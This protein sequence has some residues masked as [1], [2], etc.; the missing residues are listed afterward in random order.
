MPP[1]GMN[2]SPEHEFFEKL[3]RE[4]YQSLLRCAR[5]VLRR[6]GAK[7]VSVSGRAEEVVQ[8]TFQLAWR[9][10]E[11]VMALEYP[12]GWLCLA[13]V[14]KA[15][16]A[17]REDKRWVERLTLIAHPIGVQPEERFYADLRR[18][19]SPEEYKLLYRLYLEGYTYKELCEE[20]DEKKS[21][22]AMRA[23]R[24]KEKLQKYF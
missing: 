7:T 21:T 11:T 3:F 14:W 15:R 4:Q 22:L 19:L 9:K 24:G 12:M 23:K 5:A 17:I 6:Y 8:E 10:R 16:E 2:R 13:T 18:I 20:F 1:N